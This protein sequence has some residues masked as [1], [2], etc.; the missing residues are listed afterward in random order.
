MVYAQGTCHYFF[1]FCWGE[2]KIDFLSFV[3]AVPEFGS[4]LFADSSTARSA[5]E[6][7]TAVQFQF[8]FS[9]LMNV[10]AGFCIHLWGSVT[11]KRVQAASSSS[12]CLNGICIFLFLP[13]LFTSKDHV[14]CFLVTCNNFS[15]YEFFRTTLY[16]SP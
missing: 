11:L 2:K 10:F 6:C 13:L 12:T 5:P 16:F 7:D 3:S 9:V 8:N 15:C 1:L 14:F 4:A